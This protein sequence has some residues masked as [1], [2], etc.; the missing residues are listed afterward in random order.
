[1]TGWYISIKRHLPFISSDDYIGTKEGITHLI[2]QGY[3]KLAHIKG[4]D[5]SSVSNVRYQAFLETLTKHKLEIDPKK[6]I[7]C[8]KFTIEEGAEIAKQLMNMDNKPD[9]IF[10][11]NDHVAIGVLKGLKNLGYKV[12]EDV[13]VLGFSNSDISEVCTPQLSTIHQPGIEIG[14][15]SIKLILSNINNQKDIS[16]TKI[17]LKTKLIKREST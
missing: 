8:V 10:C 12:P 13:A 17:V 5:S 6:V 4:L 9:A 7:S 16:N 2:K 1:M 14:K 11:I 3:K 15:Q